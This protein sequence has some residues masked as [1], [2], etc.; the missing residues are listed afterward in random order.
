MLDAE[1][2][3]RAL[4]PQFRRHARDQRARLVGIAAEHADHRVDRDVVVVGMP[5]IVIGDHGDDG[6]GQLGLARELGLGHRRHADDVAAPGAIEIGFGERRELRPL[7]GE[8]GAALVEGNFL[9]ARRLGQG[10]GELRAHRVRHRD[11]RDEA[12]AE[13]TF[14][15]REGAVDELVRQHEGAGR[16]I[17][18]RKEP[19]AETEMT[20]VTPARFSASILAR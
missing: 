15:A 6:V 11:M 8:I 12:L 19:Q 20:S 3:R 10:I 16:Q 14:L 2:R 1:R 4:R 9:F 17:L 7:H 18:L 5:A 13:E